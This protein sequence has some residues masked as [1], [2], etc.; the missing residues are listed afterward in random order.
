MAAGPN[1]RSP[2]NEI[3][4]FYYG[5]PLVTRILITAILVI[6]ITTH[7]SFLPYHMVA[8]DWISIY[9]EWK[10]HKLITPF[11]VNVIDFSII[12]NLYLFYTQSKQL[13]QTVFWNKPADYIYFLLLTFASSLVMAYA[14]GRAFL[15]DTLFYIVMYFWSRH[16]PNNIVSFFFGITFPGF[17]L[18]WI[19]VGISAL[20]TA[21]IPYTALIGIASAF[22]Y[23]TFC[24][25]YI[26]NGPRVL[27]APE[28]L[29]KI[30]PSPTNTI[31]GRAAQ[32]SSGY[33]AQ[34][35]VSRSTEY[36]RSG[37]NQDSEEN[38]W[39]KGYRLG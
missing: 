7:L 33:T 21:S 31:N 38:R 37:S 20:F 28:F 3:A 22:I 19:S 2:Q 27:S 32:T 36:R 1:N 17:Y 16:F 13:E 30:L 18:P 5:I 23:F 25:H 6:S 15:G 10:I 12:F 4:L 24:E 34:A 8:F 11:F 29:A 39:G 26:T 14:M 9:K 35:P